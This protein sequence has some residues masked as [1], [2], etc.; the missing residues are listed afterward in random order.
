VICRR[1]CVY[2]LHPH[3][4]VLTQASQGKDYYKFYRRSVELRPGLLT[5]SAPISRANTGSG[6]FSSVTSPLQ[7]TPTPAAP[8]PTSSKPS[9][10]SPVL[11]RNSHDRFSKMTRQVSHSTYHV[12]YSINQGLSA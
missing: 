1:L 12:T 9:P 3:V 5:G 4:R 8:A 6:S 10:P 11:A 7:S 2:L